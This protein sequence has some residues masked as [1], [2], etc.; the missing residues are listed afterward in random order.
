MTNKIVFKTYLHK[1]DSRIQDILYR[2]NILWKKK[3]KRITL[4]EYN[5]LTQVCKNERNK[6]Q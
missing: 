6:L 2:Q 3:Q 1:L 5:K 4:T